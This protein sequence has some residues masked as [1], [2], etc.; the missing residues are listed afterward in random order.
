VVHIQGRRLQRLLARDV[1]LVGGTRSQ[2]LRVP[3]TCCLLL[4]LACGVA[5]RHNRLLLLLLLL[6]ALPQACGGC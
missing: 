1:G 3:A 5:R 4:L 2:Q 6:L